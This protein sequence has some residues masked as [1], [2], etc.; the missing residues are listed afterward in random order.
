MPQFLRL[1]F[2]RL[3]GV[4]LTFGVTIILSRGLGAAG[5]GLYSQIVAVITLATLLTQFGLPELVVRETSRMVAKGRSGQLT[6]LWQWAHGFIA[7]TSVLVIVILLA[8]SLWAGDAFLKV[9]L[10]TVLMALMI[11]PATALSNLRASILRGLGFDIL[12]SLP[13]HAIRLTIFLLGLGGVLAT[14]LLQLTVSSALIIHLL[15]Y[16]FA[17]AFGAFLLIRLAPEQKRR[18]TRRRQKQLWIRAALFMASMSGLIVINS[19]VDILMLGIWRS[20]AEVGVYRLACLVGALITLGHQ[21]MHMYAMPHL[22]K[23]LAVGDTAGLSQLVARVSQAS[24]GFSL[25]VLAAILILGEAALGAVFGPEFT[26]AM[27]ILVVL[28]GGH[29]LQAFSGLT[30]VLLVMAREEALATRIMVLGTV[31]NVVFNVLFIPLLGGIGAAI[32]TSI[33]NA[34]MILISFIVVKRKFDVM[35]WPFPRSKVA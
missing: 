17:T 18:R 7:L 35:C 30:H 20:D 14:G 10:A 33:S 8:A 24:T 13:E 19:S 27:P 22:A 25:L 2:I 3:Y 28:A 5:F 23:R 26:E 6:G 12:G 15:A 4:G 16:G 21:T 32:A 11:I 29:F 9:D 1:M 34:L 31:F